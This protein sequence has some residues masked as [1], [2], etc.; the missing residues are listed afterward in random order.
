ME[1]NGQ[2]NVPTDLSPG[3]DPL[4]SIGYEAGWDPEPDWRLKRTK[5]FLDLF[6]NRTMIPRM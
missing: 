6:G 5:S 3:K 4:A 2:F 1:S